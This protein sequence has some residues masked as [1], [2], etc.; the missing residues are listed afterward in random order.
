MRT[1]VL[2]SAPVAPSL[3]EEVRAGVRPQPDFLALAAAL[4]ASLIAPLAPSRAPVGHTA[5][6][7]RFLRVAWAAFRRRHQYDV[8]VTDLDRVG[9]LVALLFRAVGA[10]QRHVLV[11]HGSIASA[12][13]LH[14]A[15]ALDLQR[16]IH[17]FVCYGP[18]V[19]RRLRHAL[20]LPAHRVVT[21]RHAADHRFWHPLPVAP[22]RLLVGAGMLHR[23]YPTLVRAVGGLDAQVVLAAHSPW[24]A[25]RRGGVAPDA[26]PPN[27][28]LARCTYREL[29]DLY[30]RSLL[31]A[32]PL[33]DTHLQA[34]SLVIY[35]AMA[36]GR[37]VVTT[38]TEGQ[39]ELD[40]VRPGETG[41]RLPPGDVA[42]WR[43]TLRSLLD[44][45][46]EAQRLGQRAREAV[47][48]G[49]NQEAYVRAMVDIVR[50]VAAEGRRARVAN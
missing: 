1:A 6:P 33:V 11:C 32:V 46:Q 19:A 37:A 50:A 39:A 3:A 38:E 23:D 30:A 15:R 35:E 28:R 16:H 48:A 13:D 34:G 25:S 2:V 26:L 22:E 43:E 20:G 17:R 7:L 29:R 5:R 40:V 49:L 27:V 36:T 45:P 41:Y 42:A 21:V 14:L 10:E 12:P 44:H 4:D 8:L 31:V 9:L 24:V 47:E 18:A